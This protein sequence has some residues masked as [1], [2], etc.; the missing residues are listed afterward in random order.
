MFWIFHQFYL[1]VQEK[2]AYPAM[3]PIILLITVKSYRQNHEDVSGCG[4]TATLN[5]N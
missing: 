4:I 3:I 2:S 5:I 1:L